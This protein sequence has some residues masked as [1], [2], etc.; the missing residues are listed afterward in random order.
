MKRLEDRI[1]DALRGTAAPVPAA[2]LCVRHLGAA[3][4]GQAAAVRILEAALR[5]DPRFRRLPEGWEAVPDSAGD[6]LAALS[7]TVLSA[8]TRPSTSTCPAGTPTCSA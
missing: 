7:W 8:A 6:R 4:S 3:T 5:R 2:E 1:Y